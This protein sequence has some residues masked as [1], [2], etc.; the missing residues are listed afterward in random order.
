V[1]NDVDWQ[2][3]PA[4]L[5]GWFAAKPAS[6]C[7]QCWQ[8]RGFLASW[9]EDPGEVITQWAG[10]RVAERT[11][12]ELRRIGRIFE[13]HRDEYDAELALEALAGEHR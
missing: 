4:T 5:G 9:D 1:P 12:D 2:V 11:N 7:Q 6:M 8:R 10:S 3:M 13:A